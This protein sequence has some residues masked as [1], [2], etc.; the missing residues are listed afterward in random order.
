MRRMKHNSQQDNLESDA[1][2]F[3]NVRKTREIEIQIEINS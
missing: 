2:H 1:L 3:A